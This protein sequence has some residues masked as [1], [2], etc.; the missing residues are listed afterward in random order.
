MSRQMASI[1][2]MVRRARKMPEG[3]RVSPTLISTP[4]FFGIR[5]SCCQTSSSPQRIVVRTASASL[6]ALR[7]SVVAESVAGYL[8]AEMMR[9]HD[10]FAIAQTLAVDVHQDDMGVAAWWGR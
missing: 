10:C 1:S 6:S 9:S 5:M 2:G 4:Y 3:P 7:R 8:P